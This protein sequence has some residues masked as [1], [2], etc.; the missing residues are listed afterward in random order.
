MAKVLDENT[1]ADLVQ[2]FHVSEEDCNRYADIYNKNILPRIHKKYLAHMVASVEEMIDEKV[3]EKD[4]I[5][6]ESPEDQLKKENE[7]PKVRRYSIV[8]SDRQP[9]KNGKSRTR[10]LPQGAV[11][12]YDPGN[13][14]KDLRIFVAHELGHLLMEYG[15]LPYNET[16]PVKDREKYAN[17]LAYFAISGKNE[18]YKDTAPD[19]VYRGGELEIIGRIQTICSIKTEEEVA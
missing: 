5:K 9:P 17:L 2:K 4:K 19:F 13:D 3:R 15:I 11:I 8:L 14:P 16:L 12:T 10:S 18:F 6:K 1:R 7:A